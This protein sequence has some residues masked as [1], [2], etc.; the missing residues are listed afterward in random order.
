MRG[1]LTDLQ[2]KIIAALIT[3]DVHARDILMDLME[4]R[5]KDVNDFE[6]QMQLRYTLENEDIIVRQVRGRG[7]RQ[8]GAGQR[9]QEKRFGEAG[10]RDKK[11]QGR[12]WYKWL[13][14]G[15]TWQQ[16]AGT[17]EV[18][19]CTWPQA[20]LMTPSTAS[21]YSPSHHRTLAVSPSPAGQ[22][23]VPVCVRV[24]G[25]PVASGGDAHDRPLLPHAH[26]RSAPQAGGCTRGSRR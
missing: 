15:G 3:I 6:W 23:A 7:M 10:N 19:V 1:Q 13:C 12:G 16:V 20:Q 25:R 26:R 11:K 4:R 5:T 17:S 21:P 2:R 24:P 14:S 18:F 8:K 22:R 9:R